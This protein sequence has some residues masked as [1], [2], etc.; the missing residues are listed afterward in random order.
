MV[1]VVVIIIFI[2][3]LFYLNLKVN[4]IYKSNTR[5]IYFCCMLN[6]TFILTGRLEVSVCIRIQYDMMLVFSNETVKFSWSEFMSSCNISEMQRLKFTV[7][8]SFSRMRAQMRSLSFSL[9]RLSFSLVCAPKCARS[10]SLSR[11]RAHMRSQVPKFGTK[12]FNVNRYSIIPSQF[13]LCP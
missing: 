4:G 1:N 9:S 11:M 6:S 3:S 12:W 13:S 2:I 5:V 8:L 7:G 10:L